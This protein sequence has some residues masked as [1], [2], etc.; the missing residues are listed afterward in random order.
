VCVSCVCVRAR[1][2]SALY[3]TKWLAV[4]RG[5]SEREKK[6]SL[7]AGVTEGR[8][9]EGMTEE[10][11]TQEGRT[12]EERT[13][14]GGKDT[15]GKDTGGKDTGGKDTGGT[16][17]GREARDKMIKLTRSCVRARAYAY[18]RGYVC[19]HIYGRA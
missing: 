6:R 10:G 18:G 1:V 4:E 8:T 11:G 5:L 16:V 9:Q 15:G 13:R 3:N 12:E 17:A 19:R 7:S 14:E 2:C